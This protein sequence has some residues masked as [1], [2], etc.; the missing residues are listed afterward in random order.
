MA[1]EPV[2]YN[3]V[4]ADGDSN[5]HIRRFNLTEEISELYHCVLELQ[6][7]VVDIDLEAM[8]GVSCLVTLSRGSIVTHRLCG[9]IKQIECVGTAEDHLVIQA[10][11]VPALWMLTQTMNSRIFQNQTA[12]EI[13]CEIL[14]EDLEPYARD[15]SLTLR[16]S[17]Y[18][19]REYCVQ[20]HE[21][22][23]D[24]VRRLLHEEGISFYFDH[25]ANNEN[26]IL[27]DANSAYPT[28]DSPTGDI[29]RLVP[30]S[31]GVPSEEVVQLL[32]KKRV[33]GPTS[34]ILR[35]YD[36][37]KPKMMVHYELHK[38]DNMQN[39]RLIYDSA[40]AL[41]LEAN[42]QDFRNRIELGNQANTIADELIVGEAIV[43]GFTPGSRFELYDRSIGALKGRYLITSIVH[44][45]TAPS[46]FA[47]E[48]KNDSEYKNTFI[49]VPED[50]VYRPHYANKRPTVGT[51]T[52]VVVG[53]A[54][55]E[56]YT[57]EHGR[58]KVQF[59]WDLKG[60]NNEHSSCWIRVMQSW[61]G[62]GFGTLF[63]PRIG[64]EVVV[65]FLEGNAD[66]PIV[67]GCVYNGANL[68][69]ISLPQEKTKSGITTRSSPE[70]AGYNE[71]IF[72]DAC[73]HEEIAIRAQKDLRAK[74]LNDQS[75]QIG[76]DDT[77]SVSN[78]QT[79]QIGNN[80]NISVGSNRSLNV[81]ANE[82]INVGNDQTATIVANQI[83]NVGANHQVT[84]AAQDQLNIGGNRSKLIGGNESISVSANRKS[85]I[86][87]NDKLTVGGSQNI[88]IASK[89]SESV[90]SISQEN[91]GGAK[92]LSIGGAYAV[93]VGAAMSTTVAGINTEQTGFLKIIKAGA[94][95]QLCCGDSKITLSKSGEITIEGKKA[96]K[97]IGGVI[98][99][100]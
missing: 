19:V 71:L 95:I 62:K 63:V 91:I 72:E 56:V 96:V 24:F 2:C 23:Y 5:W 53:P 61:A 43:S 16:R 70:C 12:V 10:E 37:Q 30:H 81:G 88:K 97:V 47:A 33:L 98:D 99:L 94:K 45:G 29:V 31:A 22:D 4:M 36:W 64:M 50:K 1:L 73:G 65:Q 77:E 75:T 46:I 6:Y 49:C 34:L 92:T 9:V 82:T 74:I 38:K 40:P 90:G 39:E 20:Y 93:N 3:F 55:E 76:H 35:E 32:Q 21:S 11:I 26:I 7:P 42:H 44:H 15:V 79:V 51:Q 52:A 25:S 67:I 89:K 14:K 86:T 83:T 85:Q 58:I 48:E 87:S 69:A 27:V 13:V 80:Q 54:N 68:T 100:N 57:D 78:N 84:V 28:Y 66:R 8:L 17:A 60:K 41:C 18:A 59:H